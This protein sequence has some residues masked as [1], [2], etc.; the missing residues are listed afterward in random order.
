DL[1]DQLTR[2][3][4]T[5]LF[6]ELGVLTRSL[7][8]AL[9]SFK[10]DTRLS[11]IAANEI[12]DAR[13]RLNHVID[14]TEKAADRTLTAIETA[15]PLADDVGSQARALG[16]QWR[17]FRARDMGVEEF[18]ELS[19]DLEE[20]LTL[21]EG[22]GAAM[23]ASL[24]DALMAQD[25]QDLTG[26]IIRRVI[27]L[28]QELE[29]K[30]VDL[31]RISGERMAEEKPAAADKDGEPDVQGYGPAVPGQDEDVVSG[32]DEVDDLLSSLGF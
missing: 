5:E 20:F 26:Q 29:D 12:P 28:V 23:N 22:N 2:L 24:S 6:R 13:E 14:M 17:R 9:K 4:E 21:A 30:L 19:R 32:Q 7:H 8:E 18:R 16:E 27:N 3:R 25:Y 1:I 10:V 31:V 15:L 11:D